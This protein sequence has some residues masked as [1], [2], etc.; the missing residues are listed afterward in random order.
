MTFST[1]IFVAFVAMLDGGVN[2]QIRSGTSIAGTTN[3]NGLVV[4]SPFRNTL[5]FIRVNSHLPE[6][7][8]VLM[9]Y[10]PFFHT[11]H[12]SM[13]ESLPLKPTTMKT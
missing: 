8:P 6:R 12:I 2:V 3:A 1:V 13:P 4:K 7:V 10:E 11:I 5:A 9:K